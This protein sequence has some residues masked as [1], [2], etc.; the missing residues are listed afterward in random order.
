MRSFDCP[1]EIFTIV[2]TPQDNQDLTCK[3]IM[4]YIS[5]SMFALT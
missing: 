4:F 2:P 3:K 1:K 5:H